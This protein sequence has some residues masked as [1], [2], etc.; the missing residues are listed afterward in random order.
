M[1]THSASRPLQRLRI[2]HKADLLSQDASHTDSKAKNLLERTQEKCGS[3]KLI[4]V[5]RKFLHKV[6]GSLSYR[7]ACV[8]PY[9]APW[10][11]LTAQSNSFRREYR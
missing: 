2:P 10:A 3:R 6:F 9:C 1:L 11:R 7:Q 5:D 4:R 8:L